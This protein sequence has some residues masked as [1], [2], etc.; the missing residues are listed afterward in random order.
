MFD[1]NSLCTLQKVK[2]KCSAPKHS[3][4]DSDGERVVDVDDDDEVEKD[5]DDDC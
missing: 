1:H 4:E 3:T 5:V 2:W